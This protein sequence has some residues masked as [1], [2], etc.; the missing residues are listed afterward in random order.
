[1]VFGIF[2]TVHIQTTGGPGSAVAAVSLSTTA[3]TKRADHE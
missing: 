2:L 3:T 1:M